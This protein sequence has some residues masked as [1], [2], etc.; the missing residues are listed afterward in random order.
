MNR[1]SNDYIYWKLS[2]KNYIE[3]L[4]YRYIVKFREEDNG[5]CIIIF[6]N[7]FINRSIIGNEF[8]LLFVL[9]IKSIC[10]TMPIPEK[11]ER[12]DFRNVSVQLTEEV[13]SSPYF[14]WTI[15]C[16]YRKIFGV[17]ENDML[18]IPY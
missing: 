5:I 4:Y 6:R 15:P 17:K 8:V 11:L 13:N 14:D 10:S 18:K 9:P 1:D 12:Y 16:L 7:K 3:E 2:L